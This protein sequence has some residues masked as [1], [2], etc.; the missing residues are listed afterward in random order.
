MAQLVGSLHVPVDFVLRYAEVVV[1]YAAGPQGRGLL[2]LADADPL[3]HEIA[4]LLDP[5]IDVIGLLG[6]KKAPARKNRNS[7]H[8]HAARAGDQVRGH[9]HF[10]DLELLKFKLAPKSLRRVGIGRDEVDAVGLDRAVHERLDA[11][12]EIGNET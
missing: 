6:V 10:A 4:G 2:V 11:L 8:V 7:N 1:Q 5:G 3:A 9:G 12:I